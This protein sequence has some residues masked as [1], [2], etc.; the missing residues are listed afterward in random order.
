MGKT[1][2]ALGLAAHAAVQARVPV[3]FFSLEMSHL[4]LAQRMLCAEAAGRRHPDAQRPRCSRPTGR[5]SP[6]PSAGSGDAPLFIDDNPNVTVMDIRA[7]AR[8]MQGA[9]A[10]SAWWSSTTCS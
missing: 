7:K 3:L 2:F 4:E 10:V 8:R 6:T 5:R 9:R 1:A